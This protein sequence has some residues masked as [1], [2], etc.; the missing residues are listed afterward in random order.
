MAK[1]WVAIESKTF[2][3]SIEEIKGKLKGIIVERSRGFSSWIRFGVSSLRKLLECF[4]ECCREEKKGRLVKVWEEEGRKFQLERRVNGAG[5]YVLCSVVDVEA[6][7]FCLVFPEGKGLIGGWA[8]LAEKLRALGIVTKKE[9]KG[10]E[11]WLQAGGRGLRRREEVLGRCL[12]GRWEGAAMEMES[13]SFKNW[14]KRSWNLRKGVKVMKLGEPFF[15]LEFEDGG[16]AKRVLNRGTRRFKDKLLHLE[17]WNEEAGCLQVGSQTKEVWVRVVGLLLHCWSEELFKSIGDCCGGLVEVDEDTKNLSQLQWARILPR[18]SAVEP[19]MNLRWREGERVREKGDEGSRARNSGGKEQEGWCAAKADGSGAV[20]KRTGKEKCDGDKM[21][22]SADGLAGYSKEEGEVG[23][24]EKDCVGG[25]I[26]SSLGAKWPQPRNS[27]SL[28]H[29]SLEAWVEKQKD[30]NGSRA[31]WERGQSSRGGEWAAHEGPLSVQRSFLGQMVNRG[32]KRASRVDLSYLQRDGLGHLDIR[33]KAV[34]KDGQPSLA[35]N[36][37]RWSRLLMLAH[38][39]SKGWAGPA[40]PQSQSGRRRGAAHPSIT[41]EVFAEDRLVGGMGPSAARGT[42]ERCSITD[43][44]FLEEASKYSLLKPSIVCVWGGRASSSSSPFSRMGGSLL[45]MEERCG[46]EVILKESEEGLSI[47]PLSMRPAEERMR[48]KSTSGFFPL[49]EGRKEWGEEEEKDMESW[50][51]SCLAKFCHCLGMPIEGCERDILKLLHKM[52]D[53]RDRSESLSGKKRKGQRTSRFDRELKKLEWGANGKEKRKLIKD[54]IKTQKADLVCLQETKLQEMT[55]AIVRSLGVGRCLEWGALNSR[56]AGGWFLMGVFRSLWAS[57]KVEK[58]EFLSELG[59][60]KGLWNEPWCVAGDFNMIRFPSERSR[61]G[62][63]SPSMRRFT[64]VIEELE[65]RDLPLQGGMFT[66]SGGFNNLLKSRIDRFLISEDWEAHFRECIQGVLA[67]PV[68]D[69]SPIILDG[70]GMRRGPTPFR[71][72]NMWLKEEGFK[73]VLRKWWEGIQVSG[74]TSYIL[75]EKLKALKPILKKW[76]IEVFRQIKVKKQEAWNSLDL[77]DKEERVR[78]LSLEEEE[79][80][81]EAREMYKKW[82]LLEETSWRQKSREI[83]LKEEDRNTRFF[84]QMANAHRRRNQMNRVKVNGRW[85]NG[86]REIKEVGLEKPFTEEE[87]FRALS[88][89]CG[90]KAPGPDGFSMAF[91]QFSWDF[92]KEEGGAKDL[93]DFRPIS[94]V[95]GLYKWL[96]KVLAN[97]MKGVLAKVI[98]TSQ[99]DFVEGQQIMDAVLVANETIDSIVKSNRGAIL[100]KLDIEKVY[101]HVDWDFLLAVMEK[102]G[103]GERWCRWIKWCLSTVRYSV[104]VNGSPMGFF[105]SSRGLRQGNPL[106]SYLFVVVMEAFSVLIKKAVAGGF[107]APCLVRGRRGEG[108]QISHL[109]FADDTLIFCEAKE[110]QLLYM[111]WLL[112]WFEAIS[113]LRVNLEK[114]ELIPVG[115]VENVDELAD[116][117]GYRVGKLPSTYLGMPLGAPFKSVAAWD[118]IEERFKKKLAMWKHQYISKGGRITLVRSTLSNLPIYFMSIFQ[119][120]RVVRI[121]LEKIQRDFLWGG[122]ALVQ[123]PHLVNWSIVCLDKRSGGLGV[124]SLGAFNRA[125]LG[126][127]VWRFANER[128]ALWNQVIRGKYGEERGGWRSCQSRKA[129]GFGLWKAISKMGN[130]VTPF[131]GFVVGDGEKV[132][133][134]KDKWCET[135]PLSEAFPSLFALASNKEAWVNEVWTTEGEWGGSWNPCFNRPF[136]DWELEEVERLFCCLGGRRLGGMRRIR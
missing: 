126:K 1:F 116:E 82:V 85:Y 111:G 33:P 99:N 120:P 46:H 15:L 63:L 54:V 50:N 134:W 101:D 70:G 128:K 73:E 135:I 32:E 35:V 100:Y 93:K 76:N 118:G 51:Y 67:R 9:D 133:F 48:E 102:M 59:A 41:E 74:T 78:E 84:H 112:M 25:L 19:M 129:Y 5:R 69:H 60:I 11:L 110:D 22:V 21:G 131:V 58:E 72:E 26:V 53:K 80:R 125:L 6:K 28:E 8:I 10:E 40:G 123:K 16:E 44:C 62:R 29:E 4:E 98:S 2:E 38:L 92:V 66:W 71:F 87:V 79:A 88:G 3:V 108:V 64:E 113:G 42:P 20:R 36:T 57:V 122:G 55:S 121:R 52:R 65:L 109:L 45:E 89:C 39:L 115:R 37:P 132:K 14:G 130:Q 106:S 103:F 117:F 75:S 61:G 105:Q 127:W 77:W 96:A 30:I 81:K 34:E 31:R 43:E 56:G 119:M 17:R 7:R 86:E 49:K 47:N 114:S 91:W 18:V 83:W 97:R 90:E 95:G 12:V 136:N 24:S 107:L 94:L 104:M 23:S 27:Q 68:S 13:D 124:K